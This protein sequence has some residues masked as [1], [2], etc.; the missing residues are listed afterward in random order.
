MATLNRDTGRTQLIRNCPFCN[1]KAEVIDTHVYL[2]KAVRIGCTE[3]H[4]VTKKI[5][6]DHPNISFEGTD[7]T[8]RY[9]REQAIQKAIDLWNRRTTQ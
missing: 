5:L 3:C 9:T 6:I 8:T 4:C 1:G 7:E 2:D